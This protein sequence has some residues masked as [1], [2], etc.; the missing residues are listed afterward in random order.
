MATMSLLAE[1]RVDSIA[2]GPAL[3]TVSEIE[4]WRSLNLE[5][6]PARCRGLPVFGSWRDGQPADLPRLLIYKMHLLG[7]ICW[8]ATCKFGS[9][10]K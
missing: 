3:A 2:V 8:N 7:L 10:C 5:S 6:I 9:N 4:R 1:N